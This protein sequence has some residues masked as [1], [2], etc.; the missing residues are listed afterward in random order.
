MLAK[1]LNSM[2]R[3]MLSFSP[4]TTSAS[5]NNRM[6]IIRG[7]NLFLSFALVFF[8]C[9]Q[10]NQIIRMNVITIQSI[11][12]TPFHLLSPI[13]LND[14]FRLYV[15]ERYQQKCQNL[16]YSNNNLSSEVSYFPILLGSANPDNSSIGMHLI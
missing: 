9:F 14:N 10:S 12:S 5:I 16:N 3:F 6:E 15:Q 7:M 11:F 4:N 13:V 1:E 2:A 8:C